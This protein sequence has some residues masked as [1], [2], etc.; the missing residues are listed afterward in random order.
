M[1]AQEATLRVSVFASGGSP[2]RPAPEAIRPGL[3]TGP[4][5]VS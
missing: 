4:D 5:A 2:E 1:A 3:S